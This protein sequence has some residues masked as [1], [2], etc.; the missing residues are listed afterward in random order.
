MEYSVSETA[1]ELKDS[2][3]GTMPAQPDCDT[4]RSIGGMAYFV[5]KLY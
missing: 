2:K 4:W 5:R 1:I 3:K